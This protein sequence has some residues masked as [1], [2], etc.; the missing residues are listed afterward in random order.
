MLGNTF[1]E[2]DRINSIQELNDNKKEMINV[3]HKFYLNR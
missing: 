3:V 1:Q 2:I